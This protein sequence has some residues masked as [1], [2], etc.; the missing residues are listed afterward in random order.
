ME[1]EIVSHS[2]LAAATLT[3]IIGAV[4]SWL[5][6]RRLL[7]PLLAPARRQGMLASSGFARQVLRFAWHLT[8]LAWWGMAAMLVALGLGELNNGGR[9]V[10]AIIAVTLF[11]TGAVILVT[12]RGR[13]LAWP[14]FL[15]AA[16]LSALPLL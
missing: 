9:L 1:R 2:L 16:G 7:G 13:H 14:V 6:E 8:T 10:L 5:G 4:H 3:L 12:S 11:L 15:A